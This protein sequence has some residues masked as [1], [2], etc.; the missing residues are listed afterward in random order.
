MQ[1]A[2]A[3]RLSQRARYPAPRCLQFAAPVTSNISATR[4][5]HECHTFCALRP[6]SLSPKA[7]DLCVGSSVL[8]IE[9]SLL[10]ALL[11]VNSQ[12]VLEGHLA[13]TIFIVGLEKLLDL[14][15]LRG[16]IHGHD[17]V[18]VQEAIVVGVQGVE[19]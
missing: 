3:L 15:L 2:P 12:N 10:L 16:L 11:R 18:L 19:L 8:L 17:V 14:I 6:G 5:K 4:P 13:V 1:P 7:T 9:G